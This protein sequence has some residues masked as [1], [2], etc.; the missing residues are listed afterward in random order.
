MYKCACD[1]V[2]SKPNGLSRHQNGCAAHQASLQAHNAAN[3]HR[4]DRYQAK[5]D[6]VKRRKI[7]TAAKAA[8]PSQVILFMNLSCNKTDT[9]DVE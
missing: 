1:T 7:E 6:K 5:S 4:R 2:F 3:Q 9:F 8:L